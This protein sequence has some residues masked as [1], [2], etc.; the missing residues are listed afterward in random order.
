MSNRDAARTLLISSIQYEAY[1]LCRFNLAPILPLLIT[2]FG[3]THSE[4]GAL[5]SM[6]FIS[7]ALVLLPAG[8]LGDLLGP[9]LV[10][11]LGAVVSVL[12]NL[13]FSCSSSM[14]VMLIIQF[15]NGLGQGMA[16]G[17]LTRLMANWYPREKMGFVMTLLSIPPAL[18]PPMAYILSGY[19]ASTYG[20][21]SAF[22]IPSLI[23][24]ATSVLFVFSVRDGPYDSPS[25]LQWCRREFFDLL[26]KREIWLVGVTYLALWVQHVGSWSGCPPS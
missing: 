3:L 19:L 17:P 15:A 7:Y 1:Y 25:G 18:G 5:S 22:Q 6:L 26:K 16:W 21:K 11:T 8:V 24:A 23:L 10:I 4:A 13:L 9:R 14:V 2:G 20:W 12:M